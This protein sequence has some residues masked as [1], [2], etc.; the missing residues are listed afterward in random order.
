MTLSGIDVSSWQPANITSLVD[1]DFA[2]I[3]ATEG[4]GMVVSSCAAQVQGAINRGKLFG[5]YHFAD[6]KDATAEAD[7]F[8]KNIQGWIGKGVL[9]LDME[10]NAL[11]KGAGWAKTFLDRVKAQTGV[12][13][14]IYGSQGNICIPSYSVCANYP[15]WVAAYPSTA[16]TGFNPGVAPIRVTPWSGATI[17]Q[18]SSAGALSGYSGRL[19]LNV[20]YGDTAAWNLLAGKGGTVPAPIVDPTPTLT[21]GSAGPA[22]LT[23]QKLLNAAGASLVLDSSF[24]PATQ[25][26]VKVYQTSRGLQVD[27]VCGP[28]TWGALNSDKPATTPTQPVTPAPQP[29]APTPPAKLTVDGLLGPATIAQLQRVLGTPIDGIISQPTST[30]VKALQ[31]FLNSKGAKLTVDGVWGANTTKAL[32]AYLGTPADGVISKP[33]QMVKALQTRLN[34][35]RL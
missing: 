10:A 15:L 33:S 16:A 1:Y 14:I 18:Y 32:Q 7:W 9:V 26:A 11:A 6:G 24:G 19:D 29:V 4:T 3:K 28:A 12:T 22:V 2:I 30:M 13:P 21:L 23:L 34:T 25:A 5:L 8:V 31:K 35:G 20:F 27:G 17:R